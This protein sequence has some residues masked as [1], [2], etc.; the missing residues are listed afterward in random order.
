[1]DLELLFSRLKLGDLILVLTVGAEGV[2]AAALG[3]LLTD[4]ALACFKF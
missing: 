2:T 4:A 3:S 1:M